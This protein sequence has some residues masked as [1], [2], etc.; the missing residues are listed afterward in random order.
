M[1]ACKLLHGGSSTPAVVPTTFSIASVGVTKARGST[2]RHVRS[3]EA[4]G[5]RVRPARL[6]RGRLLSGS[7][8]RKGRG[9][10][11]GL[12]VRVKNVS[13]KTNTNTDPRIKY[14]V[15]V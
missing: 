3:K 10:P 12:S 4:A 8:Q 15:T 1:R 11:G 5:R 9:V 2:A 7:V 13:V 6:R 14:K